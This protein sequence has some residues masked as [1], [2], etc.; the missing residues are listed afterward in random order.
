MEGMPHR[1]AI[2][3]QGAFPKTGKANI[4]Q[5]RARHQLSHGSD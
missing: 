1:G 3:P 4:M 5:G 2:P